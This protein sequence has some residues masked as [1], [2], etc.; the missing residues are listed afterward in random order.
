MLPIPT[1]LRNAGID[2]LETSFEWN[3]WDVRKHYWTFDEA[4]FERSSPFDA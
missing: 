1:Y 3:E 2:A 4:D